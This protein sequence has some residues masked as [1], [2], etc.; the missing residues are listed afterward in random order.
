VSGVRR[1]IGFIDRADNAVEL[2]LATGRE[3]GGDGDRKTARLWPRSR[4]V[5]STWVVRA[6]LLR[7]HSADDDAA[8]LEIELLDGEIRGRA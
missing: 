3:I 7:I 8:V 5:T 2:E 1:R 6:A 4:R